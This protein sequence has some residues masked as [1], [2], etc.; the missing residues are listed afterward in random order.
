M[1]IKVAVVMLA[2]IVGIGFLLVFA[3]VVFKMLTN[4]ISLAD[5]LS[6]PTGKASMSRFQLFVFTLVIAGLYLVLS[7]ENGQLIEIPNGVL[8]ILGISG[9]SYLISKGIAKNGKHKAK[10]SV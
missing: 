8:G 6:E 4:T 3:V 2:Y 5:L 10:D 7:L 9:G 1:D